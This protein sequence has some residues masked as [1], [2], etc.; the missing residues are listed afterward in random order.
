M[1]I[2]HKM[3]LVCDGNSGERCKH[4]GLRANMEV[5]AGVRRCLNGGGYGKM[6]GWG[7]HF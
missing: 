4:L 3:M 1:V 6:I 2:R 5:D 7:Y